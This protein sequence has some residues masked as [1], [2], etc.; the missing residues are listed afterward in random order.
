MGRNARYNDY[1]LKCL[2]AIKTLKEECLLPLGEIRCLV[3]LAG[4]DGEIEVGPAGAEVELAPGTGTSVSEVTEGQSSALDYIQARLGEACS[5]QEFIQS[6]GVPFRRGSSRPVGA[7]EGLLDPLRETTRD[8]RVMHR[9]HG[10]EWIRL[11]ITPDIEIHARGAL[12][13]DQL[14]DF[15]FLADLMRHILLRSNHRG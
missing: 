3:N 12:T 13:P 10:Q 11:E 7:L 14:H 4:P 1:H 5:S 8:E 15:E 6:T 9:A 2:Q